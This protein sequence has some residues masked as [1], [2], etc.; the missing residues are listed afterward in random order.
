MT[1]V[2]IALLVIVLAAGSPASAK[3]CSLGGGASYDFL[4]DFAVDIS[5]DDYNE[6][7]R[8]STPAGVAAVPVPDVRKAATSRISLDLADNSR[9]DLLLTQADGSIVGRGNLTRENVTGPAEAVGTIQANK[10][11]LDVTAFG[12]ALYQFSLASEGSTVL[13][14]YRL[15]MPDKER[16]NGTAEGNWVI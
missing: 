8:E 16:Q 9:I 5:M 12:E 13:G 1:R 14:D 15:V 4:G 7:V 6:F 3:C 2:L 10:L 11:S